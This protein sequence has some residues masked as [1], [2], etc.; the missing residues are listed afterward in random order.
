MNKGLTPEEEMLKGMTSLWGFSSGCG[1][2]PVN[3]T[4]LETRFVSQ[5]K[6]QSWVVSVLQQ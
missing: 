1:P 6:G 3:G 5:Q 4:G 2:P